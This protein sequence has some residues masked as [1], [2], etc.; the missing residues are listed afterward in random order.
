MVPQKMKRNYD[1]MKSP[2]RPMGLNKNYTK[3]QKKEDDN[4]NNQ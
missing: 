3:K 4:D 2:L 1:Q